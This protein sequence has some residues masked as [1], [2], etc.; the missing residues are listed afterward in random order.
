M[1]FKAFV[2][3]RLPVSAVCLGCLVMS[4]ASSNTDEEF[5]GIASYAALVYLVVVTVKLWRLRP[6]ALSHTGWL[7]ALELL[8]V[9][10]FQFTTRG[11]DRSFAVLATTV[12]A[13]AWT[14]PNAAILYSQRRK[15]MEPAKEKPGF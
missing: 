7:L 8:G 5:S 4:I 2:L 9:A 15:F 13:V 6:G 10:L 14:L 3:L 1:W 12:V 11:V